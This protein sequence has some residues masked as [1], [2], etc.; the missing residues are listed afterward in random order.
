M[1]TLPSRFLALLAALPETL[2]ALETLVSLRFLLLLALLLQDLLF[3]LLPPP[4]AAVT[5][6][7]YSSYTSFDQ[8]TNMYFS[9]PTPPPVVAGAA[10]FAG[11]AF[12]AAVAG[13]AAFILV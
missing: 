10:T 4:L 3:P 9:I 11:S 8:V 1:S 12:F 2:V 13:I 6:R 5:R 7:K